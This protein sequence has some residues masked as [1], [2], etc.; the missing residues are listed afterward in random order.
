MLLKTAAQAIPNF[1]MNL[2]QIPASVCDAIE[3]KMNG[4]L[5]GKG[6]NSKCIRWMS[7]NKLSVPKFG[8]GLGMRSLRSFNTAMLA[9]QCWKILNEENSLVSKIVKARY[10]PQGD[11]LNAEIGANPSYVW[12]SLLSAQQAIR[13]GCRRRIGDGMS[14]KFWKVPWL[15]CVDN[16]YIST[17]VVPE[18]EDIE[19]Q[20]LF[21]EGTGS[22]DND[23]LND[24][25]TSRD[26]EL[27]RRI[28]IPLR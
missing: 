24:I 19:V 5:W 23:I 25:F 8:G 1:L 11:F 14:M 9:K 6:T 16:G 12:R 21:D 2:F 27:I 26:R 15:P 3:N 10:F 28:P 22:R 7:W 17:E 13:M 20:S 18:L 4:F